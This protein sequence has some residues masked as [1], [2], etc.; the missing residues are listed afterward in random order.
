MLLKIPVNIHTGLISL[1]Y[2]Y[3]IELIYIFSKSCK[4]SSNTLMDIVNDNPDNPWNWTELSQN[5]SITIE[6]ALDNPNKPWEW[7]LMSRNPS[8]TI[9]DIL[10]NPNQNWNLDSL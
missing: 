2:V 10:D 9:E 1:N 3:K 5:P 7:N 4:M 8:I 6:D